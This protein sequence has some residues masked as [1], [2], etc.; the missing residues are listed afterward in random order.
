MQGDL[1]LRELSMAFVS[2]TWGTF[3]PTRLVLS[4]FSQLACMGGV[5]FVSN[6]PE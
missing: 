6:G 5:L 2:S 1:L 4:F 3:P